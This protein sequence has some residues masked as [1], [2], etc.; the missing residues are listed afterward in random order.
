MVN[1]RLKI[2]EAQY[3]AMAA[4]SDADPRVLARYRQL[5]EAEYRRTG[6]ATN[7][8]S[9]LQSLRTSVA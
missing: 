1:I 3:Q 8:N 4:R 9:R 7:L 2:L 5:I 6:Q